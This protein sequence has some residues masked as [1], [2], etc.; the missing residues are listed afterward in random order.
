[1]NPVDSKCRIVLVHAHTYMWTQRKEKI[2][3]NTLFVST[4]DCVHVLQRERDGLGSKTFLELHVQRNELLN[5]Q[6]GIIITLLYEVE[7]KTF[8]CKIWV[9]MC[10]GFT[11]PV[12]EVNLSFFTQIVWVIVIKSFQKRFYISSK[13]KEENKNYSKKS[14]HC[15]R[16]YCDT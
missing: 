10:L 13:T 7:P 8:S 12:E 9:E 14:V 1:M 4:Y 3:E 6:Q 11:K 2:C 15:P 16:F 5:I